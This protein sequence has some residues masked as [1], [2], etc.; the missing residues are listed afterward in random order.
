MLLYKY[1]FLKQYQIARMENI[2]HLLRQN[3][4]PCSQYLN[5][6]DISILTEND[7]YR[8]KGEKVQDAL[9]RDHLKRAARQKL[10]AE[11]V[12]HFVIVHKLSNS[13]HNL[14]RMKAIKSKSQRS[15]NNWPFRSW[16]ETWMNWLRA[17]Q[18][19]T[20]TK[21]NDTLGKSNLCRSSEK[22]NASGSSNLTTLNTS[23][24]C[25]TGRSLAPIPLSDPRV[26]WT[27]ITIV[28]PNE[29]NKRKSFWITCGTLS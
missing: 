10:I 26:Q 3:G 14:K 21:A 7:I 23:R 15:H 5:K 20:R 12:R 8:K 16:K 6:Q 17:S 29:W 18:E 1:Y 13:W 24:S 9:Y 25:M 19:R 27:R 22:S 2:S 28:K 11:S 4:S